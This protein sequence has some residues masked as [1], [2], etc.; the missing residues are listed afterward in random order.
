MPTDNSTPVNALTVDVEE[1]FHV[2]A[3]SKAIDRDDWA[4]IPSR[5]EA[6]TQRL[7]DLFDEYGVKATFFTLGW[8]A[9]RQPHLVRE[10]VERGHELACHGYSHRLIYRQSPAEFREETKRAKDLLEQEGQ[11]PVRGYR[12]ASYSIT[13]HSRWA[14][15]ILVECGLEYDSSIF[16]VRHDLYGMPDAERWPHRLCT[17][18]G[19][20]IAE[21]PLSTLRWWGVNLPIAGGGYFR[22]YP[23]IFSRRGLRSINNSDRKP[24]VFY[25]HP[26]EV[27]PGQ[28]RVRVTALSCFRHYHNLHRCQ[29]RLRKLLGEFRFAPMSEVLERLD[30]LQPRTT[31]Q[32]A[33]VVGGA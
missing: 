8:V 1:Y 9:E 11:V 29:P 22:I 31:A 4:T 17:E 27:D 32:P 20:E 12:A 21:F 26:W 25:L 15:Q 10:I 13:Q 5:V 16:P 14:L 33:S 19:A 3:L 30:L 6:N 23:Y 24:F 2:A 28:P 18:E 7:L